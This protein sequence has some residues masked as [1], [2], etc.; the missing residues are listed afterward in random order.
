MTGY[1]RLHETVVIT[2]AGRGLGFGMARRFAQAGAR[3][4]I[5]ERDPVLGSAAASKLCAEGLPVTFELLDVCDPEQSRALVT[6]VVRD[7]G[8]IGTWINNAGLSRLGPQKRWPSKTGMTALRPC[9][10]AP[11]I[12]AKRWGNICWHTAMGSSLIS[13]Q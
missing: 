5:A 13:H 1:E 9:F 6:R 11:F 10:R 3:V 2:G 12:V 8:P 4:I 7:G